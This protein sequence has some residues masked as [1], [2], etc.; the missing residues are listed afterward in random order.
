MQYNKNRQKIYSYKLQLLL[1]E[2]MISYKIAGD[3]KRRYKLLYKFTF[4]NNIF[5]FLVE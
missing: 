1:V 2:Y 3:L 4:N 5:I